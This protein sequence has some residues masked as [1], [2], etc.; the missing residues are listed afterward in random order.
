MALA[1]RSTDA[2][3]LSKAERRVARLAA[4][5]RRN[6]E[7]AQDLGI[8]VK[9]VEAHLARAYRKLGVRSRTELA[10][11]RADELARSVPEGGQ[12]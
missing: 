8:D 12:R 5:G 6:A 7:I 4:E 11:R 10:A 2:A 1:R 3:T 9:T